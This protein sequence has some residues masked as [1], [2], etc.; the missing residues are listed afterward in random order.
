M[1]DVAFSA[2]DNQKLIDHQDVVCLQGT[3]GVALLIGPAQAI[4]G[5]FIPLSRNHMVT[6]FLGTICNAGV[7]QAIQACG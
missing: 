2:T 4:W 6:R 1:Q 3:P 5:Y 7:H